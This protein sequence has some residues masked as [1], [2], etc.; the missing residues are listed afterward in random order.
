MNS[1]LF[2]SYTSKSCVDRVQRFLRHAFAFAKNLSIWPCTRQGGLL[3]LK[4]FHLVRVQCRSTYMHS[5]FIC[6]LCLAHWRTL[7]WW[8][9][10][11]T[12]STCRK[13]K[14]EDFNMS[15]HVVVSKIFNI[16][17]DKKCL[18]ISKF[19]AQPTLLEISKALNESQRSLICHIYS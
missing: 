15:V 11:L 17:K 12:K 18:S 10:F 7:S 9:R 2:S 3:S 16:S 14:T 5:Y 13:A 1:I 19:C 4:T 6:H 8:W